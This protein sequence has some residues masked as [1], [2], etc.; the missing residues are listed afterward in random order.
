MC[1][2]VCEREM[3]YAGVLAG[4]VLLKKFVLL[5]ID[6]NFCCQEDDLCPASELFQV[7]LTDCQSHNSFSTS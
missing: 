3:P 1:V 2:Y 4:E 6:V 7:I 5:F